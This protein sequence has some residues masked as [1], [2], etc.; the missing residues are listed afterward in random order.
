MR[1]FYKRRAYGPS[2]MS[3]EVGM[4]QERFIDCSIGREAGAVSANDV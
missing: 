4:M 1:V 2:I 3:S